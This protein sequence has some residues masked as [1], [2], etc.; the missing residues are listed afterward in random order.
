MILL[1]RN[2]LIPVVCSHMVYSDI[3][4][5]VNCSDGVDIRELV[6]YD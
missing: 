4:S 1:A 6:A 3:S 2:Y 5:K